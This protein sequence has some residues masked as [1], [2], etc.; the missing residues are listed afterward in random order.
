MYLYGYM[1]SFF[2]PSIFYIREV[3][4][5]FF[6]NFDFLEFIFTHTIDFNGQVGLESM[7]IDFRIERQLSTRQ[8]FFEPFEGKCR[9]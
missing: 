6:G 9:A 8:P 7:E 3:I 4:A 2:T 5:G 1:T